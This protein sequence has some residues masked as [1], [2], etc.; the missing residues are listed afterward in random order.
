M[1]CDANWHLEA[2]ADK[3][4]TTLKLPLAGTR[5]YSSAAF[6]Y[7]G[8]YGYYWAA[9][10]AGTYG[11]LVLLSSTLGVFPADH[12]SRAFGFSVRCLRD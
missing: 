12:T 2:T 6:G 4:M 1:P 9:S 5:H 3:F 7:Q 10:T 8:T 11:N